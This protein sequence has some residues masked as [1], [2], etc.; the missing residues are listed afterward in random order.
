MSILSLKLFFFFEFSK[1]ATHK[2]LYAWIY[3]FLLT[4]LTMNAIYLCEFLFC[5]TLLWHDCLMF[6]LVFS[7]IGLRKCICDVQMQPLLPLI[8]RETLGYS[9]GRKFNQSYKFVD[10]EEK[11]ITNTIFF[12]EEK[13][14]RVRVDVFLCVGYLSKL[15]RVH[16]TWLS[17]WNL[18][19]L[20]YSLLLAR[21]NKIPNLSSLRVPCKWL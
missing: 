10:N 7:S 11:I 15:F 14:A 12:I 5:C 3:I 19:W 8:V 4:I 21:K 16:L 20:H 6:L 1:R 17:S 2:Y 13:I 18:V 9:H